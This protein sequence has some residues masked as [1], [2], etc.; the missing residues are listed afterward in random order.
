MPRHCAR[1]QCGSAHCVLRRDLLQSTRRR[2]V[3]PGGGR[4]AFR[5]GSSKDLI[6]WKNEGVILDFGKDLTWAKTRAWAPCIATKNGKYYFYFSADRQIGVAVADKPTGPFRDPLG[7]PLIPRD[8]YD[9]QVIDPMVF[10]DDDGY[11][12]ALLRKPQLQRG[13]TERRYDFVRSGAGETDYAAGV[14]RRV[15]RSQAKGRLLFDVVLFRHAGPPLLRQLWRPRR[16]RPARSCR[17][18]T[19]RS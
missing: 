7:K 18:R 15:V 9:C 8:S 14:L 4:R 16:R 1:R 2:T 10:V 19:I 12:L 13:Q 11:R 17:R 5:A 3:S 6:E